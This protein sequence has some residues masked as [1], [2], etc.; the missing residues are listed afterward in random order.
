MLDLKDL[1][2]FARVVALENL[3]AAGRELNMSPAVA[4]K[5]IANLESR[6]GVR[7]LNRTTR[8]V[9]PTDDGQR[10]YQHALRILEEVETAEASLGSDRDIPHGR[11]RMSAPSSFGRLHLSGA[12]TDFLTRH[13]KLTIDLSLSDSMVDIVDAGIDIAIRIGPMADSTLI[14]RRLAPNRRVICA[15]PAYLEKHGLPKTPEDL[16]DHNCLSM[17][18]Q[19]SWKIMGDNQEFDFHPKGNLVSN[20][21]GA[22]HQACLKGLGIGRFSTWLVAEDLKQKKLQALLPSFDITADWAIWAVFPSTRLIAPKVRA[23]VD[24]LVDRFDQE[25]PYWDSP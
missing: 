9:S 19:Q 4:S 15:S 24:F 10:L 21:I 13:E 25:T 3:S 5:R 14:A 1:N 22:I 17:A 18:T 6:L 11:L 7:L 2:L 8:R 20:E 16:N 23:F 12:I